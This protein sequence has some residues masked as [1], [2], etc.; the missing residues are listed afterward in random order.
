LFTIENATEPSLY[1]L[2]THYPWLGA[3]NFWLAKAYEQIVGENASVDTALAQAQAQAEAF[4]ACIIASDGLYDYPKQ[5]DCFA[6]S[7]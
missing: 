3:A 7:P 2:F 1:Q 5:Q 4:Q 6:N